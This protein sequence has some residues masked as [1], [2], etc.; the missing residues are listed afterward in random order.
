MVYACSALWHCLN[1]CI[2][3]V[4][5]DGHCRYDT[6]LTHHNHLSQATMY[7]KFTPA[8][9]VWSFGIMLYEIWSLGQEPY[10]LMEIP[11]VRIN[12][13]VIVLVYITSQGT[14]LDLQNLHAEFES[15]EAV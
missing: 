5:S 14:S 12:F 1:S 11:Q 8:S 6:I 13:N 7:F 4:L 15:P 2:V 9:M 3:C 10:Q